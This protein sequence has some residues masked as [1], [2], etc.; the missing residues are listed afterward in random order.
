[1]R[2]LAL[3]L[4][5]GVL[6][7]LPRVADAQD[8]E[9]TPQKTEAASRFERGVELYND[10]ALD[11]AMIEFERAYE[12]VSDYRVLYNI[13]R[14][15]VE[16][17]HYVEGIQAY[18]RYLK[19]G[20]SEIPEARRTQ[21]EATL[22]KLRGRIAN[23]WVQSNVAGAE[24]FLN[25]KA[26]GTLPLSRPIPM[27]PGTCELRLEKPGYQPARQTLKVAG[28]DTPRLTL[29]LKVVPAVAGPGNTT[30]RVSG[31]PRYSLSSNY[32]PFWL[33]L[34]AA[35]L[36]GGGAGTFGYLASKRHDDL[37]AAFNDFPVDRNRVDTLR[38]D[39]K[40]FAIV[41]DALTAGAI[42][43]AGLGIYFLVDPPKSHGPVVDSAGLDFDISWNRAA[44]SGRF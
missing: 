4:S 1:M 13:A 14:V 32:T 43:S 17:N 25:G 30:E 8:A 21:I 10:G 44:L 9:P 5:L 15:H 6:V 41:S 29:Q 19:D 28:G 3:L 16:Q 24:L 36:L 27:N 33:S 40:T 11:G 22:E 2:A 37:D 26:I 39:G 12:L 7:A 34:S 31:P 23:V 18:E 38:Q 20:G 42:I 35:A